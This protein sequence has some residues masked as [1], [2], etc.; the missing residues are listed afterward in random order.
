MIRCYLVLNFW[1]AK[2]T[3]QTQYLYQ[4]RD[5]CGVCRVESQTFL[6]KRRKITRRAMLPPQRWVTSEKNVCIGG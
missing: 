6:T 2:T 4:P 1:R 5:E 3:N